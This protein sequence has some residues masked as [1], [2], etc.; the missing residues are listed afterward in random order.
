MKNTPFTDSLSSAITHTTM[1]LSRL[2]NLSDI[3]INR[4]QTVSELESFLESSERL[5]FNARKPE[6]APA[7]AHQALLESFSRQL[8]G[9]TDPDKQNNADKVIESIIKSS[10]SNSTDDKVRY[11]DIDLEKT[12]DSNQLFG[13][14][15]SKKEKAYLLDGISKAPISA[16][17]HILNSIDKMSLWVETEYNHIQNNIGVMQTDISKAF[18]REGL[19]HRSVNKDL[20]TKTFDPNNA[21]NPASQIPQP[22][23]ATM[24]D[25]VLKSPN[26][27]R[28]G[29]NYVDLD[30][31][32]KSVSNTI[33]STYSEPMKMA[34]LHQ[35][36]HDATMAQFEEITHTSSIRDITYKLDDLNAGLADV[37]R[38]HYSKSPVGFIAMNKIYSDIDNGPFPNTNDKNTFTAAAHSLSNLNNGAQQLALSL[39]NEHKN[40]SNYDIHQ[41]VGLI[42]Q[43]VNDIDLKAEKIGMPR[44]YNTAEFEMGF[45]VKMADINAGKKHERS[46]MLKDIIL[47]TEETTLSKVTGL[48][49]AALNSE[50]MDFESQIPN[51]IDSDMHLGLLHHHLDVV[52]QTAAYTHFETQTGQKPDDVKKKQLRKKVNEQSFRIAHKSYLSNG[53]INAQP[54]L[55][56]DA[57]GNHLQAPFSDQLPVP[58]HKAMLGALSDMTQ[59]QKSYVAQQLTRF[60]SSANRGDPESTTNLIFSS[61]RDL[62]TEYQKI[63][64]NSPDNANKF[65]EQY[66][67]RIN[68]HEAQERDKS[69]IAEATASIRQANESTL[70][71]GSFPTFILADTN[72]GIKKDHEDLISKIEGYDP[73]TSQGATV[74]VQKSMRE[75]FEKIESFDKL[76]ANTNKDNKTVD[77]LRT[78]EETM[79]ATRKM[80]N[81][82]ALEAQDKDLFASVDNPSKPNDTY[83]AYVDTRAEINSSITDIKNQVSELAIDHAKQLDV[84]EPAPAS[85][86]QHVK[87]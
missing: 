73:K 6:F 24:M 67:H 52:S 78:Q 19:E 13:S 50:M 25:S 36:L 20:F 75:F 45:S 66:E 39:L 3:G 58:E 80:V 12:S 81:E 46:P 57:S 42:K 27:D 77:E 63:N 29:L 18:K 1:E 69:I 71:K 54:Y 11:F 60:D 14:L 49:T 43:S 70:D 7:I 74:A 87:P 82:V 9:N 79:L 38:D 33:P 61:I 55:S 53:V 64:P 23:V 37:A 72:R 2:D 30:N 32:L 44:K 84:T 65:I 31:S 21:I 68:V 5:P 17:Q 4:H 22:M 56:K 15:V 51:N 28:I 40:N 47:L 76:Y 35:T 26:L 85:T 41:A 10:Y 16:Q 86:N 59:G 8:A 62:D 34:L 48:S 83:S